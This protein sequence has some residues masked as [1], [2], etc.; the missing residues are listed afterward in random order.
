MAT[1]PEN[2]EAI[3][4]LFEAALERDP[5]QRSIFL[6]ER[7]SDAGIRAEVERLLAE[8]D[9][10]ATFHSAPALDNLTFDAEALPPTQ[11][12]ADGV[13]LAGRF[14]IIRHIAAGGM[15]SVYEAMDARLGR[16][17]AIKVVAESFVQRFQTEARTIAA[18]N[19][20]SICA[21]HDVGPNYLVMEYLEGETLAARIKRGPLGLS[22]TLGIAIA[23]A[24]ALG[25]AHLQGNRP[26]RPE[27]WQHHAHAH[28]SEAARFRS[29]E[30]PTRRPGR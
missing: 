16:Q 30:I 20:P 22:E 9:R 27:T 11:G 28:R 17:V 29:G 2:W 13:L 10:A 8:H 3:K 24:S 21:L 19:H 25:A 23:T 15:G 12:F 1:Q 26:S 6:N 14:R 18:L 7:T 4:A 5:A